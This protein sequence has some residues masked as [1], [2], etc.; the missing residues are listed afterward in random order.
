MN[1]DGFVVSAQLTL[2]SLMSST[3]ADAVREQR[4]WKQGTRIAIEHPAAGM[5]R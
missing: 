4:P 1:P 3:L 5:N 2:P